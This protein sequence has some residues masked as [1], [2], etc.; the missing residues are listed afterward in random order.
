MGCTVR[1]AA[2]PDSTRRATSDRRST[3]GG[4]VGAEDRTPIH[5]LRLAVDA[6]C[7]QGDDAA[8]DLGFVLQCEVQFVGGQHSQDHAQQ[9]AL[10]PGVGAQRGRQPGAAVHLRQAVETRN[11]LH[12][13]GADER[14]QRLVLEFQDRAERPVEKRL[15]VVR[16]RLRVGVDGGAESEQGRVAVGHARSTPRLAH[17]S[18]EADPTRRRGR[19]VYPSD[20]PSEAIST[21]SGRKAATGSA[22]SRW[23]ASTSSMSL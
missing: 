20:L 22:R 10:E 17:R 6:F 16:G 13:I 2:Q 21:T 1:L 12:C 4:S 19:P 5:P 14:Q 18:P 23:S 7:E 11:A 15:R 8:A 3:G 9:D